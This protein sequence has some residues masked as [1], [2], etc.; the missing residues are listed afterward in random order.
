MNIREQLFWDIDKLNFDFDKNKTLI[1]ERVLNYGTLNEFKEILKYYGYEVIREELKK[2]GYLE[3]KT[4][5]FVQTFFKIDKKL[6]R[7][8]TKKQSNQPHWN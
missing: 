8:Y 4:L 7:C 2:V 3:P 1:I 6:L 5:G